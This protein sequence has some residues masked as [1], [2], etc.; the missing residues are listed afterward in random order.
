V[1]PYAYRQRG[2]YMNYI[3]PYLEIFDSRQISVLIFEEFV[4]SLESIRNLYRWLGIDDGHLPRSLNEVVN[5]ATTPKEDQKA[6]LRDLALAYRE[7]IA[8]L[9]DWLGRRI[10]VWHEHHLRILEGAWP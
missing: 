4:N 1:S 8:R 2:H 5:Q 3:E 9:E 7:S 6:A 10:D